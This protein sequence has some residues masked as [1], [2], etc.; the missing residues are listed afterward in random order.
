VTTGDPVA[1]YLSRRCLEGAASGALRL[2]PSLPYWHGGESL[3]TFPA[4]VAPI[5][6]LGGELVALHR[7]YLTN[8]GRKADVPTVKKVTSAS[9]SLRGASIRLHEAV[10]PVIGVAE[11]I[12]TALAAS[13]ASGVATVAA[14]CASALAAYCWPSGTRSLVI[15]ADADRAGYTAAKDLRARAL[16]AGLRVQVLTPTVP[17]ADWCDVWA[18]RGDLNSKKAAP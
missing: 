6:T 3:G 8:D 1:Q 5:V 11:G 9:G 17:G 15:F 2:Q 14:Y 12:E 13:L 4:M 10:G 7:T 18:A 16:T